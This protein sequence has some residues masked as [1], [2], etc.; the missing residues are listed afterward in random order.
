MAHVLLPHFAQALSPRYFTQMVDLLSQIGSG[1]LPVE[2]MPSCGLG[3]VPTANKA[4]GRELEALSRALRQLP[5][6]VV[7]RIEKDRLLLDLRCLDHPEELLEQLPA[8]R[9]ALFGSVNS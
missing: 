3:L 1:S 8:L 5:R 6:P 7:G 9:S 2:R 4:I